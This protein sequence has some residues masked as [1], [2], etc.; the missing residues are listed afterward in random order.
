MLGIKQGDAGKMSRRST[1]P[2]APSPTTI[3]TPRERASMA[4]W[5]AALPAFSAMP[6]PELQSVSRKR[7]G[8]MSSP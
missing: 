3:G 8:A 4:T 7:V 6:P 5:L 1:E 2:D